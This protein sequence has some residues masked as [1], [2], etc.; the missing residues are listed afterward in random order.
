[1]G[2][3]PGRRAVMRWVWWGWALGGILGVGPGL[4]DPAGV[5]RLR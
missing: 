4:V 1:M 5:G 2:P 3:R